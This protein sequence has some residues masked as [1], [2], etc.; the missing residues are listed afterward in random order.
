[1]IYFKKWC[2][3]YV[4]KIIFLVIILTT[5]HKY[6]PLWSLMTIDAITTTISS[7]L[8]INWRIQIIINLILIILKIKKKKKIDQFFH[9]PTSDHNCMVLK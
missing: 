2:T 7:F 5:I 1:M 9:P 8:K 4:Q 6:R 3:K